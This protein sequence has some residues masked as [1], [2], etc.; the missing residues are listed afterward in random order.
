MQVDIKGWFDHLADNDKFGFLNVTGNWDNHR[1][2]L[3]LSLELTKD[4]A[5]GAE[6]TDVVE[7]GSGEGSTATLREYCGRNS[8]Y[9][10]SYDNNK[11]WAEK[12][13]SQYVEDWD[14]APIWQPCGLLFVD[15]APGHHRHAAI[16]RMAD[17]ADII[18]VHDSEEQGG[19]D[20]KLDRIWPLFK[21]RL[22]YNKTGGGA[23][24]TA[25]SNK[26]DLHQFAGHSLGG[27]KFEL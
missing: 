21:Y 12:T 23:G 20:Y 10:N 14:S 3:Y 18:V 9:F 2:L 25:L 26:I 17:K 27:F 16:A 22:N 4:F 24:A 11:D 1:P 13:N 19:G 15:H 6:R 7:L 8:R 5:N